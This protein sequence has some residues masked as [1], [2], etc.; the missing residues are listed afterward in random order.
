MS[1]SI[2]K[3]KLTVSQSLSEQILLQR[4]LYISQ[5]DARS[6]LVKRSN[7]VHKLHLSQLLSLVFRI[8]DKT[9]PPDLSDELYSR[10]R[11]RESSNSQ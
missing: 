5:Q 11:E 6:N 1:V 7:N 9:G 2:I 3:V 8:I 4:S 10:E